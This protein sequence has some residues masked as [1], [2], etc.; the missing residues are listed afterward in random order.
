MATDTEKQDRRNNLKALVFEAQKLIEIEKESLFEMMPVRI[1]LAKHFLDWQS[2]GTNKKLEASK[3]IREMEKLTSPKTTAKDISSNELIDQMGVER[4][5]AL[6][7]FAAKENDPAAI[8]WRINAEKVVSLRMEIMTIM[9]PVIRGMVYNKFKHIKTVEQEDMVNDGMIGVARAI[10]KYKDWKGKGFSE[11]AN[12]W[13]RARILESFEKL[14]VVKMGSTAVAMRGKIK[15]FRTDFLEKHGRFPEEEEICDAV[16]IS[17]A[18]YRGMYI[19]E[20]RLDEK[21]YDPGSD[22]ENHDLM[23]SKE[24]DPDELDEVVIKE[25]IAN[26]LNELPDNKREVAIFRLPPLGYE[27]TETSPVTAEE[28]IEALKKSAGEKLEKALKEES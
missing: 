12:L 7:E 4:W 14:T 13:A 17:T 18:D 23:P 22:G 3:L 1:E 8:A 27:F 26:L 21:R 24:A 9:H 5:N 25:K 15:K 20:L 11:Y 19:K 16:E 6:R 28:A 2:G 10:E